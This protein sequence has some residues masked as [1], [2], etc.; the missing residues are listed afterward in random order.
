MADMVTWMKFAG[1]GTAT[2][3]GLDGEVRQRRIDLNGYRWIRLLPNP[4]C[5]RAMRSSVLLR[6]KPL[7]SASGGFMAPASLA[8]QADRHPR[9]N[10][11]IVK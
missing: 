7:I 6:S 4:M 8:A 2:D 1:T 9:A 11:A 3:V 10:I 5:G